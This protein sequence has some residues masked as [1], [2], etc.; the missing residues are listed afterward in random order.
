[1]AQWYSS[2]YKSLKKDWLE[3]V[4]CAHPA[5]HS[6][7]DLTESPN[8]VW[9]LKVLCVNFCVY[10]AG[11]AHP[12]P[13][14]GSLPLAAAIYTTASKTVF[15]ARPFLS[16]WWCHYW[17]VGRK[18]LACTAFSFASSSIDSSRKG[19]RG[20]RR[21]GMCSPCSVYTDV[22]TGNL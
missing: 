19:E 6:R 3:L 4:P 22:N 1:M 5:K 14:L 9:W 12:V 17:L 7:Y 13:P 21:N 10:G 18:R 11:R 2:L 8:T 20:Q 15:T 16:N